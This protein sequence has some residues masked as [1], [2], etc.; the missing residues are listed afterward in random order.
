[1]LD[2][3]LKAP[4]IPTLLRP[5]VFRHIGEWPSGLGECLCMV[6]TSRTRRHTSI[7]QRYSGLRFDERDLELGG[8]EQR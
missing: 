6:L 5:E 7:V 3:C 1:M 4:Q 2:E 8:R